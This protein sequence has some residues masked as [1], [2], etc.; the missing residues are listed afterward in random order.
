MA[1]DNA[2]R[3]LYDLLEKARAIPKDRSCRQ[4]WYELLETKD[5]A[6]LMA[7]LGKAMALPQAVMEA[8]E[9]YHPGN[10]KH[11]AHWVAQLTAAF[12]QQNL[13]GQWQTFR[14]HLT[15]QTIS[16]VAVAATSLE[17]HIVSRQLSMDDLST[18]R[19]QVDNLANTILEA[20]ISEDIR[21]YLIRQVQRMRAAI[22]EY[23][24]SGGEPIMEVVEATFGHLGTNEA[25][26]D[27]VVTPAGQKIAAAL[28]VVANAITVANGF[29]PL[30]SGPGTQV[31]DWAKQLTKQL[32]G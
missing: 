25:G 23:W 20:D 1:T 26:R 30:L 21:R 28:A 3:R 19:Q 8:I 18:L 27:A 16:N 17:G 10:G 5:N 24:I 29:P 15:D 6:L 9:E 14:S 11:H 22:D 12:G 4:A 32:T 7:R 31:V 2:A 13:E